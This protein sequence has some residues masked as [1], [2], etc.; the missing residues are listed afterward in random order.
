ML[1]L[2]FVFIA[3]KISIYYYVLHLQYLPSMRRILMKSFQYVLDIFM[4]HGKGILQ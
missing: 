4:N 3:N 2:Y 1:Y